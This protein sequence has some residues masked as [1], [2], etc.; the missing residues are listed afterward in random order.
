MMRLMVMMLMLIGITIIIII[1]V[2]TTICGAGYD[3]C[4]RHRS[5]TVQVSTGALNNHSASP[6]QRANV[7]R[8]HSAGKPL[9]GTQK[10]SC[11]CEVQNT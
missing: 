9:F 3:H 5:I 10:H 8:S 6:N 2:T 1:I 11:V 7:L 4:H